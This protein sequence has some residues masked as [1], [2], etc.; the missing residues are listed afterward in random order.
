MF[1]VDDW[2]NAICGRLDAWAIKYFGSRKYDDINVAK[3]RRPKPANP[4]T[5]GTE[6]TEEEEIANMTF[7]EW[8]AMAADDIEKDFG[9]IL[10]PAMI[11]NKQAADGDPVAQA[12]I[13]SFSAEQTQIQQGKAVLAAAKFNAD[14][15]VEEGRGAASF[16]A[17]TTTAA[18]KGIEA[19]LAA[20][21]KGAKSIVGAFK[22][23][24]EAMAT[25]LNTEVALRMVQNEGTKIQVVAGG[26]NNGGNGVG[27]NLITWLTAAA[28]AVFNQ[29][30][31]PGTPTATKQS[32]PSDPPA[33][34]TTVT[35]TEVETAPQEEKKVVAKRK[36]KG[37]EKS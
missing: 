10:G 3:I 29:V 16:T 35:A 9:F 6:V 27:N 14:S 1:E 36:R 24:N 23:N 11:I 31:D 37:S 26:G 4:P 2:F 25:V 8:M 32:Q 19:E 13:D 21:A 5:N 18:A 15:K 33:N 20:R 34:V 7:E 12:F 22:G 17:Q 30:R 28:Q